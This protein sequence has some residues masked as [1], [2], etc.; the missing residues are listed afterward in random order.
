MHWWKWWTGLIGNK[1]NLAVSCGIIE[2]ELIRFL[3]DPFGFEIR[4]TGFFGDQ[5]MDAMY[6]CFPLLKFHFM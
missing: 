4:P 2:D 1:V 6:V 3:F 5:P